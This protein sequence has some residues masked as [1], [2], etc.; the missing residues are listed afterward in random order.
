[1]AQTETPF[2]QVQ[3]VFDPDGGGKDFAYTIAR[4]RVDWAGDVRGDRGQALPA[5]SSTQRVGT[6]RAADW[7]S[8]AR[9]A[10]WCSSPA[11]IGNVGRAAALAAGREHL[12]RENPMTCKRIFSGIA[13]LLLTASL[14]GATPPPAVAVAP[15]HF[16][17][18]G[19]SHPVSST[20]RAVCTSGFNATRSDGRPI[21]ITA[22][23]CGL[24]GWVWYSASGG[25]RLGTTY[26]RRYAGSTGNNDWALIRSSGN[27]RL[28]GR[29]RAG[30]ET[31]DVV[32][33]GRPR[34][35]QWACMCGRTS[36]TRCGRVTAVSPGHYIIADIAT[37]DGDSGGPLYHP[38]PG[39][40]NVVAWGI[41]S[42]RVVGTNNSKYQPIGEILGT[43][44]LTLRTN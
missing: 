15:P 26:L 11:G 13:T 4:G 22:G 40:N 14:V 20:E 24:R 8:A 38:I 34:V 30:G 32:R 25:Q 2:W 5:G 7:R 12:S 39:T 33:W 43:H 31:K 23:H 1:M 27:Y 18:W 16:G 42:G 10:R 28:P 21:V 6:A 41:L 29:I 35:G 37:R 17:G 9:W 19:I 44:D 36:G 3:A